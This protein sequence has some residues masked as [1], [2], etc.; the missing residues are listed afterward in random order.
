[1]GRLEHGQYPTQLA[2]LVPHAIDEMPIDPFSG[3]PFEYRVHGLDLPLQVYYPDN[4]R[5]AP[6]TPICWSVGPGNVR[7]KQEEFLQRAPDADEPDVEPVEVHETEYVLVSEDR[8]WG[9]WSGQ[10]LVFPLPK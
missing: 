3:Q 9:Y 2:E 1:M 4:Q 7:L 6:H 8:S 10:G 5:I